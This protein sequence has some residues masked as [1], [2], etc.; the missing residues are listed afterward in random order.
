MP[1]PPAACCLLPAACCLLLLLLL[2]P[3]SKPKPLHGD[4]AGGGGYAPQITSQSTNNAIPDDQSE[5]VHQ[6]NMD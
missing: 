5:D 3:P 2:S 6:L 1:L 4:V